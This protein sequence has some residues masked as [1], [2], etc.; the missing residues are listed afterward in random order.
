VTASAALSVGT[1][2]VIMVILGDNL[3]LQVA[4][5]N[6]IIAS[7][8]TGIAI[9][10]IGLIS[11]FHS[12][13][14]ST[15][16]IKR[17]LVRAKMIEAEVNSK[18]DIRRDY[19]LDRIMHNISIVIEKLVVLENL[20]RN[21]I[22]KCQPQDWQNIRHIADRSSKEIEELEQEV[23]LDFAHI[24]DLVRNRKLVDRS[25]KNNLYYSRYLCHEILQ[26]NPKYDDS[27]LREVRVRLR[28][29]IADLDDILVFLEKEREN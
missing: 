23:V 14:K 9:G 5:E 28:A 21:Y 17:I 16:M 4:N 24:V 19:F 27:F 29:Q 22:D 18:G 8:I 20:L 3:T 1:T 13:T 10:I 15:I 6:T 12:P 7:G 26:I 2:A 25:R 11:Y